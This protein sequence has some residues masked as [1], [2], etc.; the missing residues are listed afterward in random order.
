MDYRNE[1]GVFRGYDRLAEDIDNGWLDTITFRHGENE[2]SQ[3]RRLGEVVGEGSFNVVIS[4]GHD[5]SR[6]IRVS[7]YTEGHDIFKMEKQGRIGAEAAAEARPNDL[8]VPKLHERF[9]NVQ[10]SD[11]RLA[12]KTIEYVEY[13]P[14]ASAE[15]LFTANGGQPNPWQAD[16]YVRGVRALNDEG[17]ILAD[18]HPGNYTFRSRPG[19]DD[20]TMGLTD[21]GAVIRAEGGLPANARAAQAMIDNPPRSLENRWNLIPLE[22]RWSPKKEVLMKEG[23]EDLIDLDI[24]GVRHGDFVPMSPQGA[25]IFPDIRELLNLS[26]DDAA[27]RLEEMKR[28]F[29]DAETERIPLDDVPGQGG[30]IIPLEPDPSRF[31]LAVHKPLD[32]AA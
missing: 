22:H 6:V 8:A 15:D 32:L 25:E 16:A 1:Q 27:R 17:Y 31:A 24:L 3:S 29:R 7:K 30:A 14:E 20:L 2:L 21:P 13:V 11:P 5:A 19:T 4:D 12:G 9:S 28:A 18:A 10:S 23:F 26:P